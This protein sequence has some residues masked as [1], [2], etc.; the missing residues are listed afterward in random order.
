MVA[1][2][3]ETQTIVMLLTVTAIVLTFVLLEIFR[4][5]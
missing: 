4:G 1:Q 2:L 3:S 5:F